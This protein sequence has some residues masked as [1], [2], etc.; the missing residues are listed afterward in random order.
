MAGARGA[1][2]VDV[3]VLTVAPSVSSSLLSFLCTRSVSSERITPREKGGRQLEWFTPASA[4]IRADAPAV[5]VVRYV[6]R[7]RGGAVGRLHRDDRHCAD[8][9]ATAAAALLLLHREEPVRCE[10]RAQRGVARARRVERAALARDLG[11]LACRMS[12]SRV[13]VLRR[14]GRWP[15]RWKF[16]ND[17]SSRWFERLRES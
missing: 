9:A 7:A 14:G 1:R 17:E 3:V 8:A 10:Q 16:A 4:V 11:R 13:C 5:V 2:A 6:R 12:V 15:Q